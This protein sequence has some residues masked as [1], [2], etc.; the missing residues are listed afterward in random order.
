MKT[1]SWRRKGTV[2]CGLLMALGAAGFLALLGWALAGERAAARYP[3]AMQVSSHSNYAGLPFEYRWDDSYRTS[4]S[5]KAVYNWYS[6]TYELGAEARANGSCILLVGDRP[7][8]L[9]TRY[10][11][12]SLCGT[13]QGQM[14]FVSRTMIAN[15][16]WAAMP[17]AGELRA[18]FSFSSRPAGQ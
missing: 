17:R 6:V 15:W 5:F 7:S 18:L 1:R 11:N 2:G 8:L 12:I 14:I 9:L 16:R 10:Y 4:D 3:G 13:Q